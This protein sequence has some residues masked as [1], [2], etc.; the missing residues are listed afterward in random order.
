M[1]VNGEPGLT[2]KAFIRDLP[3]KLRLEP[4]ENLPIERDLVV[5]LDDVMEKRCQ[6]TPIHRSQK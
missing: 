1:M 4:L 6:R 2:C 5:V 3:D